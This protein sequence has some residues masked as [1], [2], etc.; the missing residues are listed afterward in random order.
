MIEPTVVTWAERDRLG[1][2]DP[3]DLVLL[4]ADDRVAWIV[5]DTAIGAIA[6][7]T[8]AAHDG[9]IVGGCAGDLAGL[10][11]GTEGEM[12][13]TVVG[14]WGDGADVDLDHDNEVFASP[15]WARLRGTI[16]VS[17]EYVPGILHGTPGEIESLRHDWVT[18]RNAVDDLAAALCPVEAVLVGVA[19]EMFATPFLD[20]AWCASLCGLVERFDAWESDPDDPVPGSEFSLR[21]APA[22][23]EA[24]ETAVAHAIVPALRDPWP[25]FAWSGLADAFVIRYDA[26][27]ATPELHVHHDVAQISAAVRLND[28]YEGG[29]LRF[30]R[31]DWDNTDVAVGSAAIWP[32][33]VTHPHV[34]EAVT[35]GRKYSLTIW[36]A[37]PS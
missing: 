5:D 10:F 12:G 33:L 30:P 35:A 31:Q 6:L 4:V 3:D 24:I 36:F 2:F 11:A 29:A 7:Q 19:N 20:P 27:E 25:E 34:G 15:E 23:F 8:L 21:L 37:L 13:P 1:T 22:L 14:A 18:N 32:S 17:D 9:A 26:I 28:G 16:F